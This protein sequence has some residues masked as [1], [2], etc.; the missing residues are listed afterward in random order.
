MKFRALSI[1][2]ACAIFVTS[3]GTTLSANPT[4]VVTCTPGVSSV[5]IFSTSSVSGEVGDYTLDCTGGNPGGPPFPVI[6]IYA[7]MNVPILDTAGWILSIGGSPTP[8]TLDS[9]NQVE[10]LAVPFDPPGSGSVD[11]QVENIFVNPSLEPPGFQF[12]E[13]VFIT[14]NVAT[15]IPNQVQ[16]VAQNAV[17]EPFMLP[18]VGLGLAAVWL[19]RR[20][21]LR[22]AQSR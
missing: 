16:V 12:S 17:P 6:N 3:F 4:A 2:S 19:A 1:L 18:F 20:V 11:L 10:F 15:E 7:T 9:S 22:L 21:N 14:G 5:P 13:T 8:G